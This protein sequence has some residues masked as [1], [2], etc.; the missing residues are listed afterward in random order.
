MISWT[1]GDAMP[2]RLESILYKLEL[3][4]IIYAAAAAAAATGK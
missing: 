4:N 3:K 1:L 2:Q